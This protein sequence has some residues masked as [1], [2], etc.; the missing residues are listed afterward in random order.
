[1]PLQ[2]VNSIICTLGFGLGVK[3]GLA[4]GG[5][6]TMHNIFGLSGVGHLA[7]GMHD[8]VP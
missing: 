3:R 5:A 1:M 8:E 2:Y 7:Y 4:I 6:P